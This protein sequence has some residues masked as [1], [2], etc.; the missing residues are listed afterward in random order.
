VI[1]D[2][3]FKLILPTKSSKKSGKSVTQKIQNDVE[4]ESE[5]TA[6]VVN[7]RTI[8]KAMELAKKSVRQNDDGTFDVGSS[9]NP[10]K[11]YRIVHMRCDC[12]GF[13]NYSRRHSGTNPTCSH[14]EAVKIFQNSN[15]T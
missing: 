13:R 12:M 1:C 3:I 9:T 5:S 2:H 14:V 8:K 4:A 6:P 7:E 10:D 15:N 11:A